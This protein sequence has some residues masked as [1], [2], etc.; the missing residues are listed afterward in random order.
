[1]ALLPLLC[2]AI[3]SGWQWGHLVLLAAWLSGFHFFNAATLV[4]KGRRSARIRA[5]LMPA[6]VTWAT[7]SGILGAA[8]IVWQPWLLAWAPVFAPLVAIAFI[9]AWRRKDRSMA[10]RISTI[11][12]SSIMLPVAYWLGTGSPPLSEVVSSAWIPVWGVTGILAAYFIGTVPYVRSLIRG[13]NDRRWVWAALIW[14][15]LT[16]LALGVGAGFG[17]VSWWLVG[18]WVALAARTVIV[19]EVQR[20]GAHIR[21]AMIGVSEFAATALLVVLLFT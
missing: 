18:F 17:W 20:R 16:G 6:L 19:P 14:H 11:L 1:M 2:G 10:A 9:E 5:R 15:T 12:A 8:L 7:A 13:K 3:L 4:L 21:P